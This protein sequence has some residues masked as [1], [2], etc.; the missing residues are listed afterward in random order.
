MKFLKSLNDKKE[1]PFHIA[2]SI[3]KENIFSDE[4]IKDI[5][6]RF[7]SVVDSTDI[8]EG[9]SHIAFPPPFYTI[10]SRSEP[11]HFLRDYNMSVSKHKELMTKT[12]SEY[13]DTI[14][15]EASKYLNLPILVPDNIHYPGFVLWNVYHEGYTHWHTDRFDDIKFKPVL[16]FVESSTKIISFT[17][18]LLLPY[19]Q[20][21]GIYYHDTIDTDA[22][23]ISTAEI[24][25]FV[26]SKGGSKLHKYSIGHMYTWPG[27]MLH[28]VISIKECTKQTP[29]LTIQMF[30]ALQE[31]H[32]IMFW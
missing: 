8:K 15:N 22:V 17:I 32:A 26:K 13:Y 9:S 12:F 11:K 28:D 16:P 1:E 7:Y 10:A 3:V 27:K 29:R 14:L 2:P 24:P 5:I 31:D 23:S 6:E 25:H 30:A 19:D 4:Q 18:P 21:P 20:C